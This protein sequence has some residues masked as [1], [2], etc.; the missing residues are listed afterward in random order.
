MTVG[1]LTSYADDSVAPTVPY[2]YE[3]RALDAAGNRSDPSNTADATLADTTKPSA[4]A[5]LPQPRRR[6]KSTSPGKPRA[7]TSQ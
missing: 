1:A 2:T 6:R 5:N 3:V 7:T 4:P